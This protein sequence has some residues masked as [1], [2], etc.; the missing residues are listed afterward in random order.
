MRLPDNAALLV[1][2][3]QEALDDPRRPPRDNPDAEANIARLLA[4]WR[5]TGRRCVHIRDD[6]LDPASL[7][8]P[9]QPG[10][11]IKEI[12][13]PLPDEW[14]IGKHVHSA[15]IG[16]NLEARLRGAGITTL[17]ITG[18]VAN[19]CV[20]STARMAGNLGF[21]TYVVGDATAAWDHIGPDGV[22][23]SAAAIHAMTLMN[24]HGEFATITTTDAILAAVASPSE[25]SVMENR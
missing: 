22:R 6:S 17:V 4:A 21:A 8:A 14:L 13:A 15:F 5:T 1:I 23:Y 25:M 10:N 7:F 2:D 11:A 20:E 24:L 18:L 3:V 9:G 12:V 19:Q 16:T